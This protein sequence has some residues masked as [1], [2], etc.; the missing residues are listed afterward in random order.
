MSG[1]QLKAI[2]DRRNLGVYAELDRSNYSDV[3]NCNQFIDSP[4]VHEFLDTTLNNQSVAI[5][6]RSLKLNSEQE[7]FIAFCESSSD[8]VKPVACAMASLALREYGLESIGFVDIN[9]AIKSDE[10]LN[11]T[12]EQ[13]Q[14]SKGSSRRTFQKLVIVAANVHADI[15]KD[16]ADRVK[17]FTDQLESLTD[18]NFRIG[19]IISEGFRSIV[20]EKV[21]ANNREPQLVAIS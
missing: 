18:D 7:S 17:L 2:I 1:D 15:N 5:D 14:F 4:D 21:P 9:E 12:L 6:W 19:I 10:V 13:I 3:L 16:A 11:S 20:D 8:A